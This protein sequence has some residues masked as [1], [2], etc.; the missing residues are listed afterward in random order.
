MENIPEAMTGMIMITL[1]WVT[2]TCSTILMN[3]QKVVGGNSMTETKNRS[4]L[5]TTIM[6][7]MHTM[8]TLLAISQNLIPTALKGNGVLGALS[9]S[10]LLMRFQLL[11]HYIQLKFWTMMSPKTSPTFLP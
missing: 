8:M 5:M 1:S 2:D 4:A 11:H 3:F 10:N 9:A 6:V 7:V